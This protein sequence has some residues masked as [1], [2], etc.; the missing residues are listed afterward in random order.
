M[1]GSTEE[2]KRVFTVQK[3]KSDTYVC[4]SPYVAYD[5]IHKLRREQASHW[6]T[7]QDIFRRQET[8]EAE[9]A[10]PLGICHCRR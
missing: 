10:M 7:P 2:S 5:K 8:A 9:L 3:N 4:V 6:R 1:Q